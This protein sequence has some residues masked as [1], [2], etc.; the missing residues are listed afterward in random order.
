MEPFD[1]IYESIIYSDVSSEG[2]GFILVQKS[3]ENRISIICTG[4]TGLSAPQ[5][6]Y[7]VFDLELSA[8]I[9][10]LKK[11]QDY[12]SGGLKF[13]ILTDHKS[14]DKFEMTNLENITSCRTLRA[15]EFIL[16]HNVTIRYVRQS[17]NKVADYLS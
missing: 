1:T 14:L 5:T 12:V 4:N 16:S 13:E 15:L 8:I 6:R 10:A 2:V 9:F 3:P 11:L 7:S 17:H